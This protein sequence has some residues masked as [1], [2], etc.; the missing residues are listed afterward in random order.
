MIRKEL[1]FAKEDFSSKEDVLQKL[2]E[3]AEKE[4]LLADREA[5]LEA[6]YRREKEFATSIGYGIAIPHGKTEA[7][8]EAFIGFMSTK[9]PFVWDK[10]SGGEAE[11]IFLIGVPAAHTETLHL[12]AIAEISKRLMREE[13]RSKLL[14]AATSEEVFEL[15][16]EIDESIR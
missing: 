15:L 4:G 10:E 2:T 11:L 5:Y 9:K 14:A 1:I 3:A 6:V 12:K 7:V 13:F 16:K 8:K